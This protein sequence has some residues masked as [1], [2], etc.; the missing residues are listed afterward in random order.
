VFKGEKEREM[1]TV[2]RIGK[3]AG[4]GMIA[5]GIVKEFCL[6]DGIISLFYPLNYLNTYK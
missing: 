5:A 6:F 1:N 3:I 4:G 2:A